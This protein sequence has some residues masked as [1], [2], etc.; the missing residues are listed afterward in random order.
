MF[1]VH[2]LPVAMVALASFISTLSG[3][4]TIGITWGFMRYQFLLLRMQCQQSCIVEALL[5]EWRARQVRIRLRQHTSHGCEF[6]PV[7]GCVWDDSAQACI[8][9]EQTPWWCQTLQAPGWNHK[10]IPLCIL[11]SPFIRVWWI[12][13]LLYTFGIWE[14]TMQVWTLTR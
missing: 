1:A 5:Y 8:P 4:M 12:T 14:G 2:S 10:G 13:A 6:L 9:C 11:A 7:G 3:W